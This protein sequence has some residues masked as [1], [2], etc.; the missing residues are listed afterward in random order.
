MRSPEFDKLVKIYTTIGDM[1]AILF[2]GELLPAYPDAKVIPTNCNVDD[3]VLSMNK[4]VYIV[5]EGGGIDFIGSLILE[6]S[7]LVSSA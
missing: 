7:E 6:A 4:P 5:R 3:W 1:P 2:V